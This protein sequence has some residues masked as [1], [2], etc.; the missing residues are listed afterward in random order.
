MC[1]AQ[2][3][4]ASDN[5]S[6]AFEDIT[7]GIFDDAAQALK[8][9]A[10]DLLKFG[11]IDDIIEEPEGGAHLD[12]KKT[13]E[14]MKATVFAALQDLLDIPAEELLNQR[15]EK[16]RKIQQRKQK[17]CFIHIFLLCFI[18]YFCCHRFLTNDRTSHQME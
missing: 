7:L 11:I 6:T 18:Y 16:Y 9:R 13:A 3:G 12:H 1:L 8:I 14:R 4:S 17:T 5:E 10:K 2:I 15:Y